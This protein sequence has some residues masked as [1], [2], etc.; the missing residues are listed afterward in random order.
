MFEIITSM[1]VIGA[2]AAIPE[3]KLYR[4]DFG[5]RKKQPLSLAHLT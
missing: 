1:T 3:S 5:I 2:R 4:E